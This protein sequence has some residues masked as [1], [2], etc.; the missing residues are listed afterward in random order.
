[1]SL[2]YA[3]SLSYFPHK[4]KVGMPELNEK[5]DDLKS[6]TISNS[7]FFYLIIS[8][9]VKLDQLEQMIRQSHHTVVITG[10]GISTDAGIPDFRGPNGYNKLKIKINVIIKIFFQVYG[11]W[12][13]E[14]KNLH[15]T[16]VLIKHYQHIHIKL[17]VN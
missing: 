5:E 14:A 9:L 1:M 7:P 15:L 2:N 13:S 11:H 16:L 17:Y 8:S 4:G 3:E 12:K 6:K 10:A